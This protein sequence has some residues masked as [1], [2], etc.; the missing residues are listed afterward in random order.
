MKR[1]FFAALFLSAFAM[2]AAQA[3]SASSIPLPA[4]QKS[5]GKPLLDAV[6][7][8]ASAPGAGFP[9]NT[10]SQ[11]EL[12]TLLWSASGKNRAD[13]WTVPFGM[14]V[15]PYVDIYVAGKEGIFRYA[16]QDHSLQRIA[17]GDIRARINP[18][19]F[20]GAASHIFIFVSNKDSLKKRGG[21]QQHWAKWTHVATGAMTQQVYLAADSLG[22]GARYAETMDTR[23]VRETLNIPADEEP[24]CIFALG[25]R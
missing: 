6:A 5:G 9:S 1:T 21:S 24:I 17:D 19:A 2:S 12:S 11:E 7:A 4:P 3:Q 25:K 20:A 15:E 23:L 10:I 14:G 13:R 22:I 18:Q 8:R 16:W